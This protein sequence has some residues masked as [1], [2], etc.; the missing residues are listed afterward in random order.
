MNN[1]LDINGY[2]A[3]ICLNPDTEMFRGKFVDLNAS[4]DFYAFDVATLKHEAWAS[5]RIFLEECKK[6]R[7]EPK[8]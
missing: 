4:V 7:V 2:K 6:H 1:V 3:I 5:L 8:N